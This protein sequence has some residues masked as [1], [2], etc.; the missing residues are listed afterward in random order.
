M[1]DTDPLA[2][3]SRHRSDIQGLRGVAVLLVVLYHAGGIVPGGYVGVDVFF[4]IS[5]F[6]IA[7]SIMR[8][9][10]RA[11]RVDLMS[12]YRRRVR[13]LLPALAVTLTLVAI[14]TALVQSPFSGQQY[15]LRTAVAA[16][17][18][19]A[20]IYLFRSGGG[21]FSP[22]DENNPFL[23]TW[24]LGVEEQF[25]L[26]FPVVV[27]I[28]FRLWHRNRQRAISIVIAAGGMASLVL[29]VVL[30]AGATVRGDFSANAER[31]AFYLPFTRA[32]QF[33][34]GILVATLVIDG[35]LGAR[36]SRGAG[37]VGL[38]AIG[39]SAL[40]FGDLTPYPGVASALPTVGAALVVAA[41]VG[42]A[43]AVLSNRG[44]VWLG[45]LSYSWYLWHWPAIVFVRLYA[46]DDFAWL[47]AVAALSLVPAALSYRFVEQRFRETRASADRPRTLPTPLLVTVCVLVPVLVAGALSQ[48]I[49]GLNSGIDPHPEF[50]SNSI[51]SDT[52]C[53]QPA[54][55][56]ESCALST[57]DEPRGTVLLIG[58]SHAAALSGGVVLAATER[59]YD[60]TFM[61]MAACPF[62]TVTTSQSD[63]CERH[64]EMTFA[65]IEAERP[66]LV[67]I[68]NRSTLGAMQF[69]LDRFE[70]PVQTRRSTT[71]AIDEWVAA[72][73]TTVADVVAVGPTVIVMSEVPQLSTEVYE[74]ALPTVVRPD[75]EFPRFDDHELNEARAAVLDP[76]RDVL[77]G[78]DGVQIVDFAAR[79]CADTDACPLRDGG[80]FLY[81]DH[82][83]LSIGAQPG[84][85]DVLAASFDAAL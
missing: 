61:G 65:A 55:Q 78:V 12:F 22:Q 27:F 85:A 24:S 82:Q 11:H 44:L 31:F 56:P 8:D 4:V 45:D 50:A 13:R 76:E 15:G 39:A 25:Y 79:R 47:V 74:N 23:H 1:N 16:S 72:Y 75:G 67:V 54:V 70:I 19:V 34:L 58:D 41:T 73:R 66:D 28:V 48:D 69:E 33:G 5:G 40:W 29:S 46:P 68:A 30:V 43:S 14:V 42:P 6:V 62:L 17:F 10:D 26:V 36:A 60:T 77:G 83:H 9:A 57:V 20:N 7:R 71:E 37:L 51:A 53:L 18:S 3:T 21:Y 63:V 2:S 32:W 35:R 81:R 38:T 52:G 84:V 80:L 64:R 59:G 49:L